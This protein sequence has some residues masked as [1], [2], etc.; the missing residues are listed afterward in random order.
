MRELVDAVHH[1]L[2]PASKSFSLLELL[3]LMLMPISNEVPTILQKNA[4]FQATNY[5][6]IARG[7]SSALMMATP[8]SWQ[9][10]L[11][12]NP[13]YC[14]S[15]ITTQSFLTHTYLNPIGPQQIL[16]KTF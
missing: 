9:Q 16:S 12:G 10:E 2:C 8:G 7:R 5:E 14:C 13:P 15:V 11:N 1:C 4:K 6:D 3:L